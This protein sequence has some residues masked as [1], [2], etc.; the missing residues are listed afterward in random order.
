M[1]PDAGPGLAETPAGRDAEAIRE[2][3][4]GDELAALVLFGA[5]PVRDYPSSH[6]WSKALQAADFVL[7]FSMFEDASTAQA[8]VVLPLQS[9]AEKEGTVTHPDGRLQRLRPSVLDPG[10]VR[11]GWEALCE[12]AAALGAET[13]LESAPEVLAAI[14]AEAEIYKGLTLEEIGGRGVRWQDRSEA[15]AAVPLSGR[16]PRGSTQL[17]SPTDRPRGHKPSRGAPAAACSWVPIA[18]SGPR[19][20]RS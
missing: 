18:T 13:G 17:P 9:H 4:V 12:L 2:G 15:A 7:A 8:D 16:G 1:L 5:D 11:P 19:R 10:S 3:L 20:S 14:A 6:G